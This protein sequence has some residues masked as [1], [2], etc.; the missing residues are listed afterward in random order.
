MNCQVFCVQ[1]SLSM[2]ERISPMNV[3]ILGLSMHYQ[4]LWGKSDKEKAQAIDHQ[5][6]EG[7]D[8]PLSLLFPRSWLV[9]KERDV[10]ENGD[11]EKRENK[12]VENL[13]FSSALGLVHRGHISGSELRWITICS[14]IYVF[15]SASSVFLFDL[16]AFLILQAQG[17]I[18]SV[19]N[20]KWAWLSPQIRRTES[21]DS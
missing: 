18:T 17:I 16:L 8:F 21:K 9:F 10:K 3:R 1:I 15:S 13:D 14:H 6:W 11:K 4:M 19:T 20:K 7:P 5:T 12:D 2:W